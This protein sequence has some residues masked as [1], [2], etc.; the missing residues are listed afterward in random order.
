MLVKSEEDLT[1]DA[2]RKEDIRQSFL[3]AMRLHTSTVA[4]ITKAHEGSA[5][6]MTATAI[7]SLSADPP[8]ILTCINLNATICRW[9]TIGAKLCIN[10]LTEEHS[11]VAQGFAGKLPAHERFQS[12]HWSYNDEGVPYLQDLL[13]SIFCRVDSRIEYNTHAILACLVE[14]TFNSK[15]RSPLLYSE[16]IF[17][18]VG[19]AA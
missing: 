14:G 11:V 16:G 13:S 7:C 18:T 9:L 1:V 15:S 17:R 4:I 10:L 3:Q 6:G 12:G 19:G 2:L 8:A 5:L